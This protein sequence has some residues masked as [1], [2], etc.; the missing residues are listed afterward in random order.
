MKQ[1]AR[2]LRNLLSY[3]RLFALQH[4]TD[5]EGCNYCAI[6]QYDAN[7]AVLA[8]LGIGDLVD[9]QRISPLPDIGTD[10]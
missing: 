4:G 8:T 5:Q 2:T 9:W 6:Q 10:Q 3:W 7:R 1:E